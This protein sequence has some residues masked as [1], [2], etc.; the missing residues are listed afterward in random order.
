VGCG[1]GAPTLEVARISGGRVTALDVHRP[2]LDE[3]ERRARKAGLGDRINAVEGS[4][5]S[6]EFPDESFDL[7][8]SEGSIFVAGFDQGLQD[9]RRLL[10][11]GGFIAVHDIAWLK[12]DPDPPAE[13]RAFWDAAYPAI[14]DIPTMLAAIPPLGYEVLGHFPL[15][16][17]A[18]WVEY[19]HPLEER[20]TR[21]RAKY[22][23]DADALAMIE[24]SQSEIDLLR[25]FPGWYSSVFFLLKKV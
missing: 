13:L 7:I 18:W 16:E 19:Y 3:L 12:P 1:S 8:W 10:R 9:W 21:L 17:D 2:Y 15:P 11:P 5:F 24:A 20:L 22:A 23:G 14:R 25:K 4:M 6:M